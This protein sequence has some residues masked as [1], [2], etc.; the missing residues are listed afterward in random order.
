MSSDILSF[1]DSNEFD[2]S[3]ETTPSLSS[4]DEGDN[5]ALEN[6]SE[7]VIEIG[8]VEDSESLNMDDEE[9]ETSDIIEEFV[10]QEEFV[11]AEASNED[12]EMIEDGQNSPD[13]NISP[14][15]D[16]EKDLNSEEDV[17]ETADVDNGE[18]VLDEI[19][20]YNPA[21]VEVYEQI[22]VQEE[23]FY[24]DDNAIDETNIDNNYIETLFNQESEPVDS[25]NNI[26]E[27][28]M[29]VQPKRKSLLPTLGLVAVLLGVGYFGYNKFATQQSSMSTETIVNTLVS[30]EQVDASDDESA[31]ETQDAMPIESIEN[32]TPVSI[33]NEGLSVSIPAIEKNLDASILVSNLK[34][35][36]EV[37]LA[38]TSNSTAKRYLTKLGKIIQLNLKSELL[39][40]SKV[41][42]SNKIALELEFDKATSRFKIKSMTVSSG[43]TSIDTVIK[44]TVEKALE[45]N[46]SVGTSS[47]ATLQGNPVLVIHL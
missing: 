22:D 30:E 47:F 46:L 41:P 31:S 45:Y 21:N 1:D 44:Q 6:D 25:E 40:L 35:N 37:P 26:I 29:Y 32:N 39:L 7:E 12:S 18:V 5:L 13:D 17:V 2:F 38:Y 19:A 27:E 23:T 9:A 10:S 24:A 33:S 15:F 34:I 14:L 43:E 20:D 36:W 28:P 42:I 4:Y 16:D 3:T 11:Y 8:F